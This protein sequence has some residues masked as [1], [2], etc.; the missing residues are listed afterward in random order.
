[1][2]FTRSMAVKPTNNEPG[3]YRLSAVLTSMRVTWVSIQNMLS[4]TCETT[5]EPDPIAMTDS[6][7]DI[8]LSSPS[9]G[10]SGES[11]EAVVIMA[12]VE[13]PCADL[14]AAAIMKGSQSP[15]GHLESASLS[16]AA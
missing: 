3:V 1:M 10:I 9:S 16:N 7:R 13:D 12:T 8:S 15:S 6:A 2:M 5:M 14:I 11:I 4:L